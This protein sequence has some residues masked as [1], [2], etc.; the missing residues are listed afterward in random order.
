MINA[1][2]HRCKRLKNS[3]VA[4]FSPLPLHSQRKCIVFVNLILRL[5]TSATRPIFVPRAKIVK[6]ATVLRHILVLDVL[7]HASITGCFRRSAQCFTILQVLG[8]ILLPSCFNITK[9]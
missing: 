3:L 6:L 1:I 9:F 4:F 8:F 7:R 5:F 2:K